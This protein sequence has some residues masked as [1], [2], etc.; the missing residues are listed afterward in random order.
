MN[1]PEPTE[2][3]AKRGLR[4]V[5]VGV[6]LVLALAVIVGVGILLFSLASAQGTGS[7]GPTTSTIVPALLHL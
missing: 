4:R 7:T 3:K 2:S 1:A 6:W 5:P